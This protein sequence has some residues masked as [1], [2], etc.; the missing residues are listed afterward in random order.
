MLRS[1]SNATPGLKEN[2]RIQSKARRSG[3]TGVGEGVEVELLGEGIVRLRTNRAR[4][5]GS[6]SSGYLT[7]ACMPVSY[8]RL[9]P[10]AWVIFSLPDAPM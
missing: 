2:T 1:S 4:A 9:R 3:Q 7:A 10:R 5:R 8:A 6:A